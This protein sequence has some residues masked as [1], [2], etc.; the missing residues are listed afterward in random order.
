MIR[1]LAVAAVLAV[2][3]GAD[4]PPARR[5]PVAKSPPA[6][7][8]PVRQTA[9]APTAR[10]SAP[11]RAVALVTDPV[12]LAALAEGGGAFARLMSDGDR[13]TITRITRA[14]IAAAGK[15]D[16]DAGVGIA[17]NSHRLFDAGW[18]ERGSYELVG[19][20][21]RIDRLPVTPATCGDVRL[22]YRL[23]YRARTAGV[24]VGS[25]LPMTV[26]IVL[27]GAP[28]EPT[29]TDTLG[30]RAAAEAWRFD[31]AKTGR[32][33]GEAILAGPLG[34]GR[35]AREHVRQVL[36]NTQVVR[37]PSGARPDLAGHAEYALRAFRIDGGKLVAAL[38]DHT[39]D[40]AKLRDR[41]QRDRLITWLQSPATLDA[42]DLGWAQLPVELTAQRSLSVSPRGFARRANR[43]F[44]QLVAPVK[45]A[46]LALVKRRAISSPEALLRRLDEHTCAG[47]HQAQT[48]AGFHLLG[49][50][51][52]DVAPGN[53]LA[54]SISPPLVAERARRE[55]QIEAV[56]AGKEPDLFRPAFERAGKT[57]QRGSRCGLG[58]PGFASWS[59]HKGLT[60]QA[61]D[62]PLDDAAIGECL[63][64]PDRRE[65]GDPC[66]LGPLEAN[67]NPRRDHGPRATPGPCLEGGCQTNRVGFPAGCVARPAT[68]S[69]PMVRAA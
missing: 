43:P 23:A 61:T 16:P 20:A 53:A 5:A 42:I 15:G 8:A 63:P 41:K 34:A 17:G 37:W 58:D 44:R 31:T 22:I 1:W 27:D 51:G 49:E 3:C 48:I 40:V 29:D 19:L 2:A 28:R 50:D 14:E 46:G 35:L 57:G 11:K 62:A 32:P 25:R 66:E 39:P 30:C 59:C 21:F 38:A 69:R 24:E 55:A 47:C 65:V 18:L 36:T 56:A 9:G 64:P 7:G 33:L 6:A 13:A 60:C 26:A 67:A 4:A 52:P 12:A 54:T 10:P 68:D 45:L